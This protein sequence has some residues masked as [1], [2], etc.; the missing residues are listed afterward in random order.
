MVELQ[1]GFANNA[2]KELARVI[3]RRDVSEREVGYYC[4]EE[5]RR[6]LEKNRGHLSLRWV[7]R[8]GR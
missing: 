3:Q 8:V 5:F 4:V 6:E 1:Y 7:L 2:R